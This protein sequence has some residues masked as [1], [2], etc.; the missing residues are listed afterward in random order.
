[1]GLRTVEIRLLLQGYILQSPG[2]D[3]CRRQILTTK[4]D[5]RVVS[6]KNSMQNNIVAKC[7]DKDTLVS[8]K[9]P[10]I[11]ARNAR[12]LRCKNVGPKS[13]FN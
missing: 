8:I 1:M 13:S 9:T 3:V 5:P 11:V 12:N 10:D 4:V 6:V 2:T 7:K